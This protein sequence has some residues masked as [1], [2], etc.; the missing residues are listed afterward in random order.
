MSKHQTPIPKN[1]IMKPAPPYLSIVVASRNDNHGGDMLKRM[2][3][4][5]NGI[6]HLTQKFK[7]PTELILVEWNPPIDK[8]YLHTVLPKPSNNAYLS[9][10]YII[11]PPDLHQQYAQ[12]YTIPLYQMTAKN[13]GIR[14]AKGKFVLCTNVDI[15]FSETL[16]SKLAKQGLKNDHFYRANRCDIPAHIDQSWSYEQQIAFCQANILKVLGKTKDHAYLDKVPQFVYKYDWLAKSLNKVVGYI[17]QKKDPIKNTMLVLDTDACGD[18]TL[19]SKQ[20]WIA[21]QGYVEVNF[22]SINIDSLGLIAAAAL[23]Y[24]QVIFAP[25]YCVYHIDHASGWERL[26][27]PLDKMRFWKSKPGF[28][29]DIIG[30]VAH[31][32]IQHRKKLD[33]NN[34]DWGFANEQ[35]EEF[36]F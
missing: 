2:T 21:I 9:I 13:V 32:A 7:L 31:Y 14:R 27:T 36:I 12:P 22:Y 5:V 10:R 30:E 19:M 33:I 11:V 15:L 23:G 3:I 25:K 20:N 4:F 34:S 18:F 1:E 28:G 24:E 17:G 6:L 16:F 26:T 29:W 35:L 8:P